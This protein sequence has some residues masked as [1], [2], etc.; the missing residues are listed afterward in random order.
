[1]FILKPSAVVA[2]P[3]PQFHGIRPEMRLTV[4]ATVAAITARPRSASETCWM[5]LT[6]PGSDPIRSAPASVSP[7]VL[8]TSAPVFSI[9]LESI[10][11]FPAV[12]MSLVRSS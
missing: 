7:S 5:G 4:S 1:M 3:L 10:S 6:H 2:F 11:I 9:S 8:C 12:S